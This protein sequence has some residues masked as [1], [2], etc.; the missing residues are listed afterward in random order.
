MPQADDKRRTLMQEYFGNPVD[1]AGPT[2]YLKA[3]GWKKDWNGRWRSPAP[4]T[5][6]TEKEVNCFCFLQDEWDH[7]YEG[8]LNG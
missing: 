7:T 3:C 4:I 8:V 2:R 1:Y 6:V 5:E